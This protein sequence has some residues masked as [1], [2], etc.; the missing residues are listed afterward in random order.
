M[1]DYIGAIY[2]YTHVYIQ[3]EKGKEKAADKK[4]DQYGFTFGISKMSVHAR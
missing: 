3:T 2:V 1:L 4:R